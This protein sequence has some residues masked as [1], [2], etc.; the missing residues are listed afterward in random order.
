MSNSSFVGIY[1]DKNGNTYKQRKGHI[2]KCDRKKYVN[3]EF[4]TTEAW[5]GV[6]QINGK[7]YWKYSVDKS[8]IE[9]WLK[10]MLEIHKS[11]EIVKYAERKPPVLIPAKF[12]EPV[13]IP[14]N[15][16]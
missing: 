8:V 11:K 5:R 16:E 9:N 7:M 6:I 2:F 10:N 15:R 4:R 13:R 3:G 1:K 14:G 12:P